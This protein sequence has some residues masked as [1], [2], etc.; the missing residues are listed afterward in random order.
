METKEERYFRKF[1][2][3][4]TRCA[5]MVP[6]EILQKMK[7]KSFLEG[8]TMGEFIREAIYEKL[9]EKKDEFEI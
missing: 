4:I 9:G 5:F 7:V 8:K 2:K 3:E 6:K 1:K